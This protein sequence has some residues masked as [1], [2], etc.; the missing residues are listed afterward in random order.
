MIELFG[1]QFANRGRVTFKTS[2]GVLI[3]TA[4]AWWNPLLSTYAGTQVDS[5][6]VRN[7]A[8]FVVQMSQR[9]LVTK[10]VKQSHYLYVTPTESYLITGL[11]DMGSYMEVTGLR[12]SAPVAF[13][14]ST[15]GGIISEYA[16]ETSGT[17]TTDQQGRNTLTNINTVAYSSSLPSRVPF[18]V[19]SALFVAASSEQLRIVDASQVELD[20]TGVMTIAFWVKFVTQPG[21]MGLVCKASSDPNLGYYVYLDLNRKVTVELSSDGTVGGTTTGNGATALATGIWYAVCVVYDGV[22]IRIY[23]NGAL[24]TST[25]NPKAHTAGIFNNGQNFCLG[26]RSDSAQFLDGYLAHVFIFNQAKTAT[27]VLTWYET[28]I[29]S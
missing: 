22:D 15:A 5:T 18:S 14:I 26:C 12:Q 2:A 27:Q 4:R 20:I 3:T 17:L 11:K 19:G 16:F 23:L 21:V 1:Q 24:D 25:N 7:T 8:L 6:D 13:A 10:L 9:R 28:D 29:W